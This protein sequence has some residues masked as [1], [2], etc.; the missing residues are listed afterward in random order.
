MGPIRPMLGDMEIRSKHLSPPRTGGFTLIE[1]MVTVVVL[2]VLLGIAAPSFV[3]VIQNNRSTALANQ[4]VTAMNLARMEAIR[5]G[6]QVTVCSSSD[7]T[8]CTGNWTDGW[9]VMVT[10]GPVLQVWPAPGTAAEITQGGADAGM[11][12]FQP[13]GGAVAGA[14]FT[15]KFAQCTGDQA[16]TITVTP[17]GRISVAVTACT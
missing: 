3:S 10:G 9:L 4:L 11:V 16:R 15:S 13:L 8:T 12:Q 17:S 5:R 6:V 1:L 7:G 14:V 2:A